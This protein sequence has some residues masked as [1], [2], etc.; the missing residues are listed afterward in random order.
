MTSGGTSALLRIPSSSPRIAGDRP[1]GAIARQPRFVTAVVC[2]VVSYMV[3]NLIMPA[4]PLAMCLCGLSQ[5]ASNLGL[6]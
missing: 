5:E 4:A 6:Q 1:I 3:M 2:S